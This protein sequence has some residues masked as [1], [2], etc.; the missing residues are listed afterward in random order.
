MKKLSVIVPIYNVEKYIRTCIESIFNQDLT[1]DDF[2]LILVNDGTPDKSMEMISDIIQAHKNIQVINQSNQG[3]SVA[4]NNGLEKASGEYIY[5][6]DSDDLLVDHCLSLLLS[7]VSDKKVDLVVAN[8]IELSNEKIGTTE[9]AVPKDIAITEN[10]GENIYLDYLS[11]Y[12]CHVWHTLFKRQF[13]L[14]NN[15]TFH[16]YIYYEDVPYM[17]ECYLKA[18]TCLRIEMPIYI[19]RKGNTMSIT[20][21]FDKRS[22]MDFSVALAKTWELTKHNG[23]SSQVANRLRENIYISFSFLTYSVVHDIHRHKE[24]M[25]ILKKIKRSAPEM[26]FRNGI[27]QKSVTFMYKKMPYSYMALRVLYAK[28]LEKTVKKVKRLYKR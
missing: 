3:P 27:R 4:R 6:V 12:D 26:R 1:D 9:T 24:R 22:G 17:H 2:E 10:S 20:S 18:Q 15:I 28:R 16:P 14:D 25:D 21:K 19:Y 13:L 11:P 8:F 5:F 7:K 23:M